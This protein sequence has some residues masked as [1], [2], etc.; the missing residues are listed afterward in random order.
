MGCKMT[1]NIQF[2]LLRTIDTLFTQ[3][4]IPY[5]LRGGWALDFLLGEVTR[6]HSD[7]DL[8]AWKGDTA[9]I[10]N[11]LVNA[12]FSLSQ[13]LGVQMDFT[14]N[15]QDIS[16]VFVAINETGQIFT[17]DIPDWLWLAGALSHPKCELDNLT[18]QVVSPAQ[19][20]QEKEEYEQATGRPLRAK[21]LTSVTILHQL[22]NRLA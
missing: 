2:N 4:N 22:I 3:A 1:T 5:W 14:K 20:L 9:A 8:V 19:L 21:D 7:I 16:V 17:P 10:H 18:C 15:G 13:D 11:L 12:G 6:P